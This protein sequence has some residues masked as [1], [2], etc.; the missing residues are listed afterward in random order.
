MPF[1]A[2]IVDRVFCCVPD[3][4]IRLGGA[5]WLRPMGGPTLAAPWERLRFGV[6]CA[7]TPNSA[8]N[9]SDVLFLL[10]LSASSTA[11][12]A[13]LSSDNFLGLSV[14]GSPALGA[15][16]LLTYTAGAGNPYF[17]CTGGVAFHKVN[18]TILSN[19]AA[20]SAMLLPLAQTGYYSRRAIIIVD[21][22]RPTGGSGTTTINV[23]CNTTAASA[24]TVDLRPDQLFDALDQPGTPV[25]RGV[26]LTNVLT[27]AVVNF[28]PVAGDVDTFE[29]FWSSATFP[30]EISALGA[31]IIRTLVY[32]DIGFAEDTFEGYSAGTVTSTFLTAGSGWSSQGVAFPTL[33]YG[34]GTN[35]A[36]NLAPQVYG[37]YV[38]TTTSPD[39]TFAQYA[40]GSVYSNVTVNLGS[41]WSG[42]ASVNST[43]TYT[44]GSL[45]FAS[46]LAP[47]TYAQFVG[48]TN[49]PNDPFDQYFTGS[50]YSGTTLNKGTY[51]SSPAAISSD[52][53]LFNGSGQFNF[54]S[55]LFGYFS[56][57]AY[58]PNDTFSSYGT[59]SG[60]NSLTSVFADGSFWGTTGTVYNSGRFFNYF[61]ST[62]PN[63]AA[64]VGTQ[65]LTGTAYNSYDTFESYGTGAVVSG[66]TLV[67]GEFWAGAGSIY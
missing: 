39:E 54:G 5:S 44:D 4:V 15:T 41:Y 59:N 25:V 67:A 19:S 14:V 22:T 8:S 31:T 34:N 6:L 46:N 29:V 45:S 65:T 37:Q 2:S 13:A 33:D 38:G 7:V 40:L 52:T 30:L 63:F 27:T 42:P 3:K 66:V 47:Q 18:N 56:G 51:W 53:G 60:S 48:T 50:V 32:T 28:S 43:E 11:P 35:N 26:T 1:T 9:I 10:G 64:L 17:S 24:Q 36:S 21:I 12:G 20:S 58:S 61:G 57:T 62:T 23:Y 49:S 16:R 55:V